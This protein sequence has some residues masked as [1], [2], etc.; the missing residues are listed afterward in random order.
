[1]AKVQELTVEVI[2][3]LEDGDDYG[4]EIVDDDWGEE[5]NLPTPKADSKRVEHLKLFGDRLDVF[6]ALL[7]V[8]D[9]QF[10]QLDVATQQK[11][12]RNL[13]VETF[14]AGDIIIKEGQDA[15]A[16]YII[17]ATNEFNIDA[18]VEVYKKLEDGSE[19][20]LTSL[21]RGHYFGEKTFVSN[22]PQ[23]RNAS[24]RVPSSC[25][26]GV[27]IGIVKSEYYSD[28]DHFRQFLVMKDVPLI[29]SLPRHEQLEMYSKL[30][31]MVY[32]S[33]DFIIKEG[34]PGEDF[35]IVLEGVVRVQDA[36][37]GVLVSL[38]AGH[39]FGEM[40]LLSDEPR[41]A[42]V[43]A[44][45]KV[46]CLCLSKAAFR[47]ALSAEKF[48]AIVN[49]VMEQRRLTRLKRDREREKLAMAISS[50]KGSVSS[51]NMSEDE[52]P[53]LEKELWA[54]DGE[55]NISHRGR[56]SKSNASSGAEV[57][58]S[59]K[60]VIK[61]VGHTKYINRYRVVKEI[62]KGSFGSVYMVVDERNNENCAMKAVNRSTGW[63]S[64]V[65]I[66]SEIEIMKHL[67][68]KNLVSL[69][70]VIDDLTAQKMFIV[71]ELVGG[72]C[73]MNDEMTASGNNNAPV[74]FSDALSRK[75]FRDMVK[76]VHYLHSLGI[77][78]RDIKPQ[79]VLLTNEGQCKLSDFGSAISVHSKSNKKLAV[80]GTPAFM[81]PELFIDPTPDNQKAP[82][83]D[84]FALGA[85][86]Y[87]MVL[88]KVPWMAKNEIDLSAQITK[89]E[90]TFPV[91]SHLDPH[92]KH[93]LINM[94][95][96]DL[97]NRLDLNSI[98]S[99]D[100]VTCESSE[101]MYDDFERIPRRCPLFRQASNAMHNRSFSNGS[102]G[103]VSSSPAP[104]S[105]GSG[106]SGVIY[107]TSQSEKSSTSSLSILSSITAGTGYVGPS[108]ALSRGKSSSYAGGKILNHTYDEDDGEMDI[109]QSLARDLDR[110]QE[111]N[112]TNPRGSTARLVPAM[113]GTGMRLASPDHDDMGSA[114]STSSGP[115]VI[116]YGVDDI[117]DV[118]TSMHA[119]P[120]QG[121]AGLHA[122]SELEGEE[123]T[124]EDHSPLK[125]EHG[126]VSNSG[127][128]GS[129]T[130]G[131]PDVS[132]KSANASMRKILGK[133]P[134][135]KRTG[136]FEIIPTEITIS[137][138]GE[139]ISK[140]IVLETTASESL[141]SSSF[142]AANMRRINSR[143][144]SLEPNPTETDGESH[145][146]GGA[147]M[148]GGSSQCG[149]DNFWTD[150]ASVA[151]GKEAWGFDGIREEDGNELDVDSSDSSD[152][153]EVADGDVSSSSLLLL[154]VVFIF[155]YL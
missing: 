141:A 124:D 24:I 12:I 35:F 139:K 109:S 99:H 33:E 120:L 75:Y 101:P 132:S 97:L 135:L 118:A 39:C 60:L 18:E 110:L 148:S 53:E 25:E 8:A 28:W 51:A 136:G 113:G 13:Q 44:Q 125:G 76:G 134:S 104:T 138:T 45:G 54:P 107:P 114:T 56:S 94:M 20:V 82:A 116:Y 42:S 27:P 87:C 31:R 57:T 103:T 69:K 140:G 71:Q 130:P 117:L 77:I 16:F 111:R 100:W 145:V 74:P 127:V 4:E 90:V 79:N 115:S 106:M 67:N 11:L 155:A 14:H 96:K 154:L 9:L 150:V 50:R 153:S 64:K 129:G 29:K 119:P 41:V 10:Y 108:S 65:D 86:L 143:A 98:I 131:T 93:L 48:S 144:A 92:L 7:A 102:S 88:G 137:A 95:E 128:G 32:Q 38:Q 112:T 126:A 49:D 55:S 84:I 40:A 105:L 15:S 63:N 3:D 19:K 17:L 66:M 34:D 46:I 147:K 68:H 83:I 62:G 70:G 89:F 151:P 73:L 43:V 85:T 1:M 78:H 26:V 121:A 81:A 142:Y 22:N 6:Y 58:F 72:G 52:F 122:I 80:A 133:Q 152:D 123:D 146:L 149:S 47:A 59:S 37:H 23:P 30:T 2:A 36:L 61:K 21:S 91:D 5:V